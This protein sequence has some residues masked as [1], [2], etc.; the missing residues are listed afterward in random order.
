MAHCENC[1]EELRLIDN[2]INELKLRAKDTRD[3]YITLLAENLKRD[4][5]LSELKKKLHLEISSTIH[6]YKTFEPIL[7]KD[8]VNSLRMIN[9][10][11]SKDSTFVLTMIRILYDGLDELLKTTSLTGRKGKQKIP[12]DKVDL[13]RLIF[14]ERLIDLENSHERFNKVN[15]HIK[16]AFL[17][18]N[19]KK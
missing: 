11:K 5:T 16:N 15:I 7:G 9:L 13:I 3:R 17:N 12:P 10:N 19:K 1:D 8:N 18:A 4:Y 6:K 14:K 2:Q